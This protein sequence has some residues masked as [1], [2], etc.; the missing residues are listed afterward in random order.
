MRRYRPIGPIACLHRTARQST[1]HATVDAMLRAMRPPCASESRNYVCDQLAHHLGITLAS[2]RCLLRR[3]TALGERH[4]PSARFRRDC[5]AALP[6][7]R[8][9]AVGGCVAASRA[10]S[11]I[12][13]VDAL[14]DRAPADCQVCSDTRPSLL[15]MVVERFRENDMVP[16]CQRVRE[17]RRGLPDGLQY[18]NSWVEANFSRCF[19]LMECEGAS[20]LQ[21]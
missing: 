13:D 19:Q 21:Q 3:T 17:A 18:V 14:R 16:V 10:T 8:R 5:G 15:F 1:V 9:G 20:I 4:L 12:T 11:V 7:Y 2:C 6:P